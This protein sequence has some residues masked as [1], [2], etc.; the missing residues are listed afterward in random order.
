MTD[1]YELTMIDA[2]MRSGTAFRPSVFEVF[3]RRL[4]GARRYGVVVGEDGALDDAGTED[5]RAEM[6][7]ARPE[8]DLPVFDMGPSVEELLERCEEETGL[9]APKRP[10]WS[11]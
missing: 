11:S 7:A 4:P 5:L 1:R 10:V 2:A 8:G 9:P 3:A 6:R